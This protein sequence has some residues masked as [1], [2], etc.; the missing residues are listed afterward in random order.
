MQS[1]RSVAVRH[2][3]YFPIKIVRN[4]PINLF[5]AP[6][7]AKPLRKRCERGERFRILTHSSYRV[8][9]KA[10]CCLSMTNRRF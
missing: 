5:P 4:Q 2:F 1:E 6:R 10:A 9:S 7:F 8:W 3:D